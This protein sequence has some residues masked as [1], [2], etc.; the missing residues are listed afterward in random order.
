MTN[1]LEEIGTIAHP[2]GPRQERPDL[3]VEFA[4]PHDGC[5]TELATIWAQCLGVERVGRNDNFFELGGDSV[6]AI[7]MIAKAHHL[8]FKLTP[9]QLFRHQTIGQLATVIGGSAPAKVAAA[10]PPDPRRAFSLSG[11]DEATL[12]MLARQVEAADE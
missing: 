2:T 8:G 12:G 10:R 4:A 6:V 9:Q 11:L 5:E 1:A 7:Q 3:Q